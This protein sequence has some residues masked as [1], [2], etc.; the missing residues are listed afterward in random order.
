MFS[1]AILN[2]KPKNQ[3]QIPNYLKGN[4]YILWNIHY[5]YVKQRQIMMYSHLSWT[6]N[7]APFLLVTS[8]SN[9]FVRPSST[10]FQ[11]TSFC[12]FQIIVKNPVLMQALYAA[13]KTCI[14]Y[15]IENIKISSDKSEYYEIP[16]YI[17]LWNIA[18]KTIPCQKVFG[19]ISFFHFIKARGSFKK[20]HSLKT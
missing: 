19:L 15:F 11:Y 12:P 3:Q 13:C 9:I 10:D 4:S 14:F 6:A 2:I 8:K 7:K 20:I 16:K 17:F 18:L 1:E 5:R